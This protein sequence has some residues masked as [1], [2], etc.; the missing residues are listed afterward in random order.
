MN[1]ISIIALENIK[2]LALKTNNYLKK[3]N[4]ENK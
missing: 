2:E 3:M 4:N 1:K